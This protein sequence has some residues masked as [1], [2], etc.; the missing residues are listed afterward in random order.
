MMVADDVFRGLETLDA[1]LKLFVASGCVGKVTFGGD[2]MAMMRQ[3][4]RF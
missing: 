2:F 3:E 4:K 1:D